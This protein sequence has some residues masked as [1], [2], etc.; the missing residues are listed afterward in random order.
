V[1][2]DRIANDD[3]V[4]GP[5]LETFVGM[6]II[7]QVDSSADPATV[8]HYRDRDGGEVDLVL[9]TRAGRVATIEVKA[10]QTVRT[11]DIR[12]IRKIRDRLGADFMAG[13]VL[14]TG[15]DTIYLDDRIWAVPLAA[16]WM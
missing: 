15:P 2:A 10:A 3:R 9:E 11:A 4:T 14:Y 13:V 7:K 5:A 16:L 6:E 1:D 8:L 12:S